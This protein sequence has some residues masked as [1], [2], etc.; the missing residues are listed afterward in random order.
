VQVQPRSRFRLASTRFGASLAALIILFVGAE[1]PSKCESQ[2]S[3]KTRDTNP[4]KPNQDMTVY[5]VKIQV[6]AESKNYLPYTVNIIARDLD[7]RGAVEEIGPVPVAQ[8]A[9]ETTLDYNKG[10]KVQIDVEVKLPKPGS[11]RSSCRIADGPKSDLQFSK[12]LHV[13]WC[14][15][16]TSR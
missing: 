11:E 5:K 16:R 6:I 3:S 12:G 7:V 9:Y 2:P 8:R 15:L 13:F 1:A 14:T 10:K 4:N